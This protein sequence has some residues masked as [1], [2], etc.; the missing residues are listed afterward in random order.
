M[1]SAG[2]AS[3]A[4]V[5]ATS[6]RKGEARGGLALRL[7]LSALLGSRRL[8]DPRAALHVRAGTPRHGPEG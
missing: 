3:A 8:R 5:L 1:W 7:S 6:Q 4:P 2:P